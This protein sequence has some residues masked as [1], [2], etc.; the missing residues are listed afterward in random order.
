MFWWSCWWGWRGHFQAERW[1]TCCWSEQ[2]L[3]CC[4]HQLWGLHRSRISHLKQK[5]LFKICVSP[6]S[7]LM[8]A[9]ESV[10]FVPLLPDWCFLLPEINTHRYTWYTQKHTKVNFIDK[11][12][13]VAHFIVYGVLKLLLSEISLTDWMCGGD[14]WMTMR[15]YLSLWVM[16]TD[17]TLLPACGWVR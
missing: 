7:W 5:L 13:W 12:L 6:E 11:S 10:F 14:V 2:E 17:L 8:S 3:D 4:L 1:A 9:G 16:F 15:S